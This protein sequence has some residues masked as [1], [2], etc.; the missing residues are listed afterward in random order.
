M[1]SNHFKL[2]NIFQVPHVQS[3]VE[4]FHSF[5]LKELLCSKDYTLCVYV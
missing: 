5:I 4:R 3:S 1:E 2:P